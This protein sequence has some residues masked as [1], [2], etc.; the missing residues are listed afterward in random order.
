[1]T[2]AA[3]GERAD[4]LVWR[5]D[6]KD[7]PVA[8]PP[9]NTTSARSYAALN[10]H[11]AAHNSFVSA[12]ASQAAAEAIRASMVHNLA[13]R[14]A[15]LTTKRQ[16]R[17]ATAGPSAAA[18]RKLAVAPPPPPATSIATAGG[19]TLSGRTTPAACTAPAARI[20]PESNACGVFR[21][22]ADSRSTAG[23]RAPSGPAMSADRAPVSGVTT[24]GPMALPGLTT[25]AA[26]ARAAAMGAVDVTEVDA[27]LG[28]AEEAAEESAVGAEAMAQEVAEVAEG[29]AKQDTVG[30]AKEP[31]IHAYRGCIIKRMHV[32]LLAPSTNDA[33]YLPSKA[34]DGFFRDIVM[35]VLQVD[36]RT[37]DSHLNTAVLVKPKRRGNSGTTK[38]LRSWL[39]KTLNNVHFALRR[40]IFDAWTEATEYD[41]TREQALAFLHGRGYIKGRKGRR[42]LVAG[43]LAAVAQCS[44]DPGLY[45]FPN[46][47]DG[48][49]LR[50]LLVTLAFVFSKVCSWNGSSEL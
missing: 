7:I 5:K 48:A 23:G 37:A 33:A 28:G 17:L 50:A 29:D 27:L 44:A 38:L 12:V 19:T 20:A 14:A 9:W 11:I 42:G 3:V 31:P 16:K 35:S 30:S 13:D 25:A 40:C 49:L 6:G 21:G 45:T 26:G 8:P 24:P 1:M 34:H 4:L 15:P 10:A 43:F 2:S 22:G 41:G 36:A 47:S 39:G 32:D 18:L 46:R